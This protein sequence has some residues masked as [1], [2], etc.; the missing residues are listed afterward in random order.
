LQKSL[1]LEIGQTAVDWFERDEYFLLPQKHVFS[2]SM[3]SSNEPAPLGLIYIGKVFV[4]K[5]LVILTVVALAFATL[6]H[7][8]T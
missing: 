2:M 3:P 4:Q 6:G 5:L 8:Y 1:P 7:I